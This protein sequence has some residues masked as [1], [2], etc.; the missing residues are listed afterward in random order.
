MV[1]K[2]HN[3]RAFLQNATLSALAVGTATIPFTH[4]SETLTAVHSSGMNYAPVGKPVPVCRKGE[5]IISAIALDHGHIYGQ[6]NGLIEA[7]A[8]LKYVYDPDPG[9]IKQFCKSYPQAIPAESMQQVLDDPETHLIAAAAVP[10]LRGALG[11]KVMEH[12]KDYFTD[13]T[14]FT[15]IAQLNAARSVA[16]KTKKKYMVYF[17]ERLHV[18]SSV[19]AG[20]LIESGEI[21]KVIQV[22]GFGPHRLSPSN[23]LPWFFKKENYGGIIADIGIH[24][25]EQFLH[26]SKSDDAQI[27]FAAVANYSHPEY[28]ELEDFGEAHLLGKNGARNYF[29]VDWFTPDGLRIWGDGRAFIL[30]SEGYIEIRKY[31]DIGAPEVQEKLFL[32]NKKGE[33]E[34]PVKGK[35]G[36]P[37]FGQ[38]ILD[39]LNRT[40]KAMTQAHAF[41]AAELCLK[42]QALAE[43]PSLASL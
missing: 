34:I 42:A 5:F 24:Q 21:G 20:Q 17:G 25:I 19:R 22:T 11:L 30:G 33:F 39:C 41:K 6:C 35:V 29:R 14:P 13:K 43:K 26:F 12:G 10:N 36:Y 27:T 7:G 1:D 15:E 37:F 18:E 8:K 2:E 38:L 32:V 3:R 9:K 28:P 4:A 31:I 23:R 16:E 40:E